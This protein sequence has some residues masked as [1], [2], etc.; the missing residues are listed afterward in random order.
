MAQN[1]FHPLNKLPE[2]SVMKGL[3]NNLEYK[4]INISELPEEIKNNG[5]IS[6]FNSVILAASGSTDTMC[7][8]MIGLRPDEGNTVID[9]HPIVIGYNHNHPTQSFGGI[10]DHG[11]W[12]GRTVLLEPHQSELLSL[13]GITSSFTYK[14]I[15]PNTSGSLYDLNKNHMLQGVSSQFE[16][17][18][19]KY[20]NE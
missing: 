6:K 12:Q 18:L 1:K 19:K 13:C 9:E 5:L 16:L 2:E 17:L 10:I 3:V 14:N 8:T 7:Y 11:N 20:Y 15:P 4:R